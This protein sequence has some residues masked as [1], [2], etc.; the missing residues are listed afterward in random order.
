MF[1]VLATLDCF[2][3]VVIEKVK[4][5]PTDVVQFNRRNEK[6]MVKEGLS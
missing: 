6:K 5:K 4:L 1:V 2:Q 3:S